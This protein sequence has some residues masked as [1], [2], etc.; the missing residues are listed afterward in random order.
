MTLSIT[1]QILPVYDKPMIY[2]PLGMLML[3][4]VREILIISTPRDLP[5]LQNLLGDGRQ[6]GL[7]LSYA[8]QP[9]PEGLAQAFI[10]GEKF[11]GGSPVTMILG[12]NIFFGHG[13]TEVL[14]RAFSRQDGGTIFAYQVRD[15]ERYG[16]VAFDRTGKAISI[17]EKPK[18]PASNWAAVGLYV[19][20]PGVVEIAKSLKPSARGE[21]EITSINEHY[22]KQG[23]LRV[24]RLGRG[25]A[26]FDAGTPDSLLDAA[27]YV[28][29][30]EKRQGLKIASPEEIA[31][32]C[33]YISADDLMRLIS[34]RYA[35]N[36]YG[37]Y[38]RGVLDEDRQWVTA[39]A[40]ISIFAQ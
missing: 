18:K 26:W 38:L 27:N 15:P 17:E 22:L 8:E 10:I 4:G 36:E 40:G 5:H 19:Y 6:W 7:R 31:Y 30:I 13:I 16:V 2:Y 35:K 11:I 3:G 24:E 28:A 14:N 32:R 29:T 39:Q 25:F 1:K 9:R 21:L 12:D 20:E 37:R 34:E 23:R 33:S